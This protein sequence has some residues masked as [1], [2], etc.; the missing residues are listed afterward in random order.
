MVMYL[1]LFFGPF[2]K[3]TFN[4]LILKGQLEK[5]PL[6]LIDYGGTVLSSITILTA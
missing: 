2:I 6:N 4:M 3:N 1:I 5:T